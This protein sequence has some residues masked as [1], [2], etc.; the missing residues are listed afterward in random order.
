MDKAECFSLRVGIGYSV[1]KGSR[2]T[3]NWV[4]LSFLAAWLLSASVL[5]DCFLV[6]P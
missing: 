2:A 4:A 6:A 1:V 5:M 3:L